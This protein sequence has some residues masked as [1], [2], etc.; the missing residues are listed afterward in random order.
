MKCL[1]Y[2]HNRVE[3]VCVPEQAHNLTSA[4]VHSR[5]NGEKVRV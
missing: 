1:V 5:I 3:V 2:A 4:T